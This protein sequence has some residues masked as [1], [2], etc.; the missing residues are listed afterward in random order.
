MAVECDK[1]MQ[2]KKRREILEFEDE[3]NNEEV[4]WICSECYKNMSK[5]DKKQ[6]IY[7]SEK[8]IT[9]S[10]TGFFVGGIFGGFAYG[11]GQKSGEHW[12]V[13]RRM[14]KGGITQKQ[15]DAKSIDMFDIHFWGL[16]PKARQEVMKELDI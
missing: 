7:L 4:L 11:E 3:N 2:Q 13:N 14:K 6:L 16:E 10:P 1:C 8:K 5:S 12:A 9:F 15:L